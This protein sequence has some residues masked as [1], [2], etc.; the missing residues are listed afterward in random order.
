MLRAL[1]HP[2]D[3]DESYVVIFVPL[4]IRGVR[5]AMTV[6]QIIPIIPPTFRGEDFSEEDCSVPAIG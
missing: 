2:N 6:V 5:I 1:A 4:R 3:K